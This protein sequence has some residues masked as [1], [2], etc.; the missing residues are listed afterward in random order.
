MTAFIPVCFGL[1]EVTL[2]SC[3]MFLVDFSLHSWCA[4]SVCVV[5]L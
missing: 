4:L 5:M 3:D 1:V 2:V